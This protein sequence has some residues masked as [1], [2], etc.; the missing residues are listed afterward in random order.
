MAGSRGQAG[1]WCPG[2]GSGNGGTSGGVQEDAQGSGAG[3]DGVPERGGQGQGTRA[4]LCLWV[5]SW[6]RRSLA[7]ESRE[8]QGSV[9]GPRMWGPLGYW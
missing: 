5:S 6:G 1:T 2:A 4:R 9:R 3:F 7:G 8:S